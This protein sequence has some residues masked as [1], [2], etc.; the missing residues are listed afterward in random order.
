MIW[1][2]QPSNEDPN[3]ALSTIGGNTIA[4][5]CDCGTQKG[6]LETAKLLCNS[7]CSKPN[8]QFMTMDLA[9]FYL[10][11]PLERPEYV[12]IQINVISQEFI[13]KYDLI[14]FAH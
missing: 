9:N 13:D 14:R 10:S 1:E 4:Y 5:Q 6:S 11:T 3:R 8:A 2:Y 12:Q 7:V